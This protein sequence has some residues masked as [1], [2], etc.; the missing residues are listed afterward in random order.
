MGFGK[1]G[2]GQILYGRTNL[3]VGALAALDATFVSDGYGGG[4][5]LDEDFRI[6][7]LDY[8]L[9]YEPQATG[10]VVLVGIA[11]GHMTAPEIEEA[12]EARPNDGNDV[13]A[14]EEVMRP[15]WPIAIMGGSESGSGRTV[16]QG[17]INVRW[18]FK[19]PEG[20][21]WWVYNID[22]SNAL[23]TGSIFHSITKY[24]GMWVT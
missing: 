9:N 10:D 12:L 16:Y 22:N 3:A 6:L 13:P 23:T 1:D 14:V 8:Y 7:K 18:T 24:F 19:N 17:S 11:D 15:V 21:N 20:W 5:G 4:S 2:R